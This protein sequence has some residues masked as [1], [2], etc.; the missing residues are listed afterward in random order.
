VRREP[1][2]LPQFSTNNPFRLTLSGRLTAP[3]APGL[4]R[5]HAVD[6]IGKAAAKSCAPILAVA[7]DIDSALPLHLQAIQDCP[8]LEV[9]QLLRSHAT[10]RMGGAS[11]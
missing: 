1:A 8:I 6:R 11:L 9:Q 10:R 2:N 7:E 5:N 3:I 4:S